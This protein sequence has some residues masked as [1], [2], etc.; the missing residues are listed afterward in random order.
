MTSANRR[1]AGRPLPDSRVSKAD[2]LA[3]LAASDRSRLQD[4]WLETFGRRPPVRLSRELLVMALSYDV[5][6]G[7]SEGQCEA[8]RRRL[9][10]HGPGW[11]TG[12][13]LG[14][15]QEHSADAS[16]PT[17]RSGVPAKAG[18]IAKSS[19]AKQRP[20]PRP[21]R[22]SIKPGTRLLREWQ[23]QTHEVIAESSGQFLYGGRTYRSLSAIARAIT[24]TRWSG[25]V[26]F[27]IAT[28]NQAQKT[29]GGKD[30]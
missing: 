10:L 7:R 25:P 16:P 3:R 24:G 13:L 18:T 14:G 17:D 5:Q 15:G 11:I 23:G 4:T 20:S 30:A 1:A 28:K 12:V 2:R 29:A 19:S 21:V 9:G 6:C 27:G 26:F 8:D 22:R